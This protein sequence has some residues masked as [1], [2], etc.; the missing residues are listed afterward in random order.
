MTNYKC[1]KCNKGYKNKT[2]YNRHLLRKTP[3]SN[4]SFDFQ[5]P[6][7]RK[8]YSSKYN[9]NRHM[10]FNC[11]KNSSTSHFS[12]KKR[13]NLRNAKLKNKNAIFHSLEDSSRQKT[14]IHKGGENW[15]DHKSPFSPKKMIT[16]DH[17]ND[18]FTTPNSPKSNKGALCKYCKKY[19]KYKTNMYRH[20]RFHCKIKRDIDNKEEIFRELLSN[21]PNMEN[22]NMNL[23]TH[24]QNT[25]NTNIINSNNVINNTINNNQTYNIQLVA[26]GKENKDAL[27][28]S[29][30][31]RILKKGY[32]SVPELVKALHFN[33][34]RPENHNI[35]VSNMRNNYIMI[36]DGNKWTLVDRNETI[37]NIFDDGREYL[38]IRHNNMKDIYND[39]QKNLLKGFE[40]FD[41]DIDNNPKKRAKIFDDI[42]LILYNNRNLP[43]Q[44]KNNINYNSNRNDNK[45]IL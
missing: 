39:V 6:R 44:T 11:S 26:F 8:L 15:S 36:Y 45:V 2:D 37:Q 28:N 43:L 4:K 30:I 1:I 23:P 33:V 35:F 17:K 9:L 16:S 7:C 18:H 41:S 22:N 10:T 3:C 42:K 21:L 13:K 5:C 20:I 31:F 24:T 14:C 19:F 25:Q 29:E 12:E 34:E 38:I 27:K 40:R 32:N